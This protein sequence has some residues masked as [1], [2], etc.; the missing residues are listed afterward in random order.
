[1]SGRIASLRLRHARELLATELEV[2]QPDGVATQNIPLRGLAQEWQVVDRRRQ[3]EI[4]V[5]VIRGIDDLRLGID[6]A[7]RLLKK[8][9]VREH[10]LLR[11]KRHIAQLITWEAG[12]GV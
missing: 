5:R 2:E 10:H 9:D 1:A 11:D 3:V 7:Q 6:D 8:T 4:P 12:M